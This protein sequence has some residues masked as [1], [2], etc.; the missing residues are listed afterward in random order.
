MSSRFH[1]YSSGM[2]QYIFGSFGIAQQFAICFYSHSLGFI[3]SSF[4]ITNCVLNLAIKRPSS[5]ALNLV[6]FAVKARFRQRMGAF[7]SE[8]SELAEELKLAG[9][10]RGPRNGWGDQSS[11]RP[12]TSETAGA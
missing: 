9:Y 11:D 12:Q 5:I 10:R 4:V 6:R 1:Q 3:Y 7:C 2:S 8:S